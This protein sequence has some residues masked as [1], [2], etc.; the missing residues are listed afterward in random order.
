MH[1]VDVYRGV[2]ICVRVW[3]VYVHGYVCVYQYVDVYVYV[4]EHVYYENV[5]MHRKH[6]HMQTTPP[7]PETQGGMFEAPLLPMLRSTL[8][9]QWN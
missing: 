5:C 4:Y 3:Y 1:H 6:V 2:C 8:E 9:G 7:T